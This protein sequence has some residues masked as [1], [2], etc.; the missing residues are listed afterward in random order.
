VTSKISLDAI[1]DDAVLD[2]DCLN[3]NLTAVN[4]LFVNEC[5]DRVGLSPRFSIGEALL[6]D[7]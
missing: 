3:K 2:L 1:P 5:S 7:L 4:Q 6:L